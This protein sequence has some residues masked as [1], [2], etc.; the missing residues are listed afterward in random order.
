MKSFL[1]TTALILPLLAG[2]IAAPD[3]GST[4]K[5]TKISK[6]EINGETFFGEAVCT[7]LPLNVSA[8]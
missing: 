4:L 6:V 7:S 1:S 5:E 8:S 2:V 3:A